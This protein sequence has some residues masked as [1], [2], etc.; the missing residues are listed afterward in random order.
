[1][2]AVAAG[3]RVLFG[4]V[5]L[6]DMGIVGVA[7]FGALALGAAL[8]TYQEVWRCPKRQRNRMRAAFFALAIV[9]PLLQLPVN[10]GLVSAQT[11][12]I[13]ATYSFHVAGSSVLV[14]CFFCVIIMWVE[15]LERSER[16]LFRVRFACAA[17]TVVLVVETCFVVPRCWYYTSTATFQA[18]VLSPEMTTLIWTAACELIVCS[19]AMVLAGGRILLH[20]RYFSTDGSKRAR[21]LRLL[22]AMILCSGCF[23]VRAIMLVLL[24]TSR[25]HLERNVSFFTWTVLNDWLPTALPLLTMMLIMRRAAARARV[26]SSVDGSALIE[27]PDAHHG[28]AF[29]SSSTEANLFGHLDGDDGDYSDEDD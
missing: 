21:I 24:E 26:E 11:S 3:S 9:Y 19:V 8:G 10:I 17:A 22:V 15:V 18:F 1:M 2:L 29:H 20:M 27:T 12:S 13:C 25:A 14:A 4:D 28:M 7:I 6:R 5:S 23:V 16:A